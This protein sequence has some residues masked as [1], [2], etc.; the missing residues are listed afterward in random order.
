MWKF[1][2]SLLK[3][4]NYKELITI[5]YLQILEIYSILSFHMIFISLLDNDV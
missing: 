2:K 3:D 5:Y 4:D 1:N